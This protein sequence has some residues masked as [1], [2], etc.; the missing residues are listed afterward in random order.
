VAQGWPEV[1]VLDAGEVLD[2][3]RDLARWLANAYPGARLHGELPFSR[4]LPTGQI[5]SGQIDLALEL[6]DGWVIVDHK[7]NP[8]PKAEWPRLAAEHSGQLAAYA[9]ALASLGGKPV[10]ETLIHFSVS[11]GLVRVSR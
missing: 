11:G 8:Q 3:A 9:D 10:R 1:G 5:Q 7:S 6:A 2:R 4:P